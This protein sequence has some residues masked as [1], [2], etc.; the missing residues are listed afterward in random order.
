MEGLF[1]VAID[2]GPQRIF[3]KT[4]DYNASA[5]SMQEDLRQVPLLKDV[6]VTRSG[7]PKIS[8]SWTI[9]FDSLTQDPTIV[10][11]AALMGGNATNQP[12]ITQITLQNFENRIVYEVLDHNFLFQASDEDSVIV[13]VDG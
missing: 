11:D 5:A 10:L 4:Y 6:R 12:N 3:A 2:L 8:S 7:N 1:A 13:V 9:H